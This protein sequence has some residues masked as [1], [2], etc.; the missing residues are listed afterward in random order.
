MDREI[1]DRNERYCSYSG[2]VFALIK[3]INR[4]VERVKGGRNT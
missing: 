4:I 2:E 1:V 3:D